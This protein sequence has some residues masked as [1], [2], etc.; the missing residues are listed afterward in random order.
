MQPRM[1]TLLERALDK[2]IDTKNY[3]AVD[4]LLDLMSDHPHPVN[5]AWTRQ[6]RDAVALASDMAW[7]ELSRT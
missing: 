5:K 2:A 7:D 1:S 4:V 6:N 3:E